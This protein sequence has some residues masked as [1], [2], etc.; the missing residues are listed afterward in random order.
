MASTVLHSKRV[1]FFSMMNRN[2]TFSNSISVQSVKDRSVTEA[3]TNY[4][5]VV[6]CAQYIAIQTIKN[7]KI[8]GSRQDEVSF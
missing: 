6:S 3:M 1:D 5:S 4:D 2:I 8:E 7:C